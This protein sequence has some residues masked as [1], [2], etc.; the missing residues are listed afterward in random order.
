[1]MMM[2]EIRCINVR[3]AVYFRRW[4]HVPTDIF[5]RRLRKWNLVDEWLMWWVGAAG[6]LRYGK[7][8]TC[9]RNLVNCIRYLLCSVIVVYILYVLN[10]QVYDVKEK[11]RAE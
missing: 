7:Q 4:L 3:E 6:F 10:V 5:M 8:V 1:M 2:D 11:I 9:R